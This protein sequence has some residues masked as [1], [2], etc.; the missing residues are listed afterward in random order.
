[1]MAAQDPKLPSSGELYLEQLD[2][3]REEIGSAM[4]AISGNSLGALEE[5]L[6]RQEILCV[7]LTRLLQA[8][9]EGNLNGTALIRM[10]STMT[11]LHTLNK[12][13]ADLVEQAKSSNHLLYSLCSSYKDSGSRHTAETGLHCSLKA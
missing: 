6:W 1:M 13:Y 7:S 10:R 2:V 9:S 5:S 4:A 3:L 8:A 12:T 11:A